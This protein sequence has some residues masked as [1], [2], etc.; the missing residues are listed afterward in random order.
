LRTYVP[1][2]QI[3]HQYRQPARHSQAGAWE[4]KSWAAA[5]C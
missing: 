2:T 3:L 1:L 4:R 5:S